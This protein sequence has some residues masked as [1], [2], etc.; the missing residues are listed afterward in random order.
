VIV[1]VFPDGVR[2]TVGTRAENDMFLAVLDEY[3]CMDLA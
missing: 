3:S 1:K 2:V